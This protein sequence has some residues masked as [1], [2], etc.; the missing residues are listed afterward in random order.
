MVS[1]TNRNR[2]IRSHNYKYLRYVQ[3]YLEKYCLD[4]SPYFMVN[5]PPVSL[6]VSGSRKASLRQ[7][8]V[9]NPTSYF[10]PTIFISSCS[11]NTKT[12]RYLCRTKC[13][14]VRPVVD[15]SGHF[16]ITVCFIYLNKSLSLNL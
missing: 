8:R 15:T 5:D 1:I 14:L 10:I 7:Q 9:G 3:I 4:S 11:Y 16:L 12:R 6:P 2:L 13:V